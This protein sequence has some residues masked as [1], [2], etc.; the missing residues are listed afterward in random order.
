MQCQYQIVYSRDLKEAMNITYTVCFI[1]RTLLIKQNKLKIIL[2]L[3]VILL[4]SLISVIS[5]TK[6]TKFTDM[7]PCCNGDEDISDLRV[8]E[9]T[10]Y[11][12]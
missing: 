1:K 6:Q 2:F 12:T 4:S 7:R 5:L 10:T 8:F 3:I 11:M 9:T